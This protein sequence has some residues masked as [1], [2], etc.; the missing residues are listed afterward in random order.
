[1]QGLVKNQAREI[2]IQAVIIKADGTRQE[3]GTID[4]WNR[5]IFKLFLWKVKKW[6]HY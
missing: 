5:N 3:L 6:L 1:M 2:E 4:Y